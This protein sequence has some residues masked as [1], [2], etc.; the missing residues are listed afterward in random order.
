MTRGKYLSLESYLQALKNKERRF[1]TAAEAVARMILEQGFEK[2]YRGGELIY[3]FNFFRQ[4]ERPVVGFYKEIEEFVN[5]VKDAAEGGPASEM[6][7]VLIGEPGNGKTFFID[8]LCN[9]Y[10][11]FLSDPRNRRYSFD[12]INLDKLGGYGKLTYFPS[13]TFEDPVI[14]GMNL[15]PGDKDKSREWL[16]NNFGFNE[17]EL[18]EMFSKYRPLGAS[19]EYVWLDIL[20]Y[21]DGNVEEALKFVRIVPVPVGGSIG[22]PTGKFS[23]LDKITSSAADLVGDEGL[24]EILNLT[25]PANPCRFDL[26]KGALARAGG[27]GIHFADELFRNKPDLIQIYIQAIQNRVIEISGYRWAVDLLILATSNIDVWRDFISLG[28]NAPIKDRCFKCFASHNTDYKVQRQLTRF[29]LSAA[30][31]NFE[32]AKIHEDPNLEGIASIAVVLTRLPHSEKLTPVEMMKLEAGEVAGD[33]S[34]EVLREIK[35]ELNASAEV[36]KRWGQEGVGQRG[37]SR[38]FQILEGIARKKGCKTVLDFF[39]AFERMV[40]DDY[41][42]ESKRKKYLQSLIT[43]R[44]LYRKEVRKSI[45]NAYRDDPMAIERAVL[46]YVYMAM[47]LD[48]GQLG[49]D[50]SWQYRDPKS[51]ELKVIKLDERYVEAVEHRL[52][53]KTAEERKA[54]RSFLTKVWVQKMTTDPSYNFLDQEQLVNAVTEVTLDSDIAGVGSLVAIL[55]NLTDEK[56]IQIQNA[57]IE[58][59]VKMGY[60]SVCAR[61]TIEYF[62]TKEDES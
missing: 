51:G 29:A 16:A 25:D 10:R 56:N 54:F 33:K 45:F 39:V 40:L 26:R 3:D 6:A 37:Y 20:D 52:G 15:F 44:Q 58:R 59:M 34:P 12:F 13:Q 32:G 42:E 22:V 31:E 14:L 43:A 53:L 18:N 57:L 55:A 28:E 8:Y 4:G 23:P 49:P 2:K 46:S 36:S 17:T 11:R 62:C 60:C 1:E 9:G 30:T 27:G 5:F 24:R 19:S 41:P 61:A 50:K 21:T 38:A 7:F 48:S 35:E 47:A